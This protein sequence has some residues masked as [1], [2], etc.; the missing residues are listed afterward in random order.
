MYMSKHMKLLV[1]LKKINERQ[2]EG[3][4]GN[5]MALIHMHSASAMFMLSLG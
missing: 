2:I 3:E 4:G 1:S 5:K